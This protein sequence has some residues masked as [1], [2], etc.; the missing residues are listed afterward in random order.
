M[1]GSHA[2]KPRWGQPMTGI[3]A[4][5]VFTAIAWITWYIFGD[6]AKG[7][8]RLYEQPFTAFLATM[9]VVGVWQHIIFGDWPF[10]NLPP[11]QRGIAMTVTNL[12]LTWF[13]IYCLFEWMGVILPFWGTE[14]LLE[15][16]LKLIE[17][18]KLPVPAHGSELYEEIHHQAMDVKMASV[19]FWVVTGFVT[20]PFWAIMFQHWPFAGRLPQPYLGLAEWCVTTV[21]TMFVYGL[22]VVPHFGNVAVPGF[23][24]SAFT[25]DPAYASY[26]KAATELLGAAGYTGY[27]PIWYA[28]LAPIG[29][30]N[31]L[32]IFGLYEWIVIVLFL[33][34]NTWLGWPWNYV[35]TQPLRGIVGSVGMVLLAYV[36]TKISLALIAMQWGPIPWDTALDAATA[37]EL[38]VRG[39]WGFRYYHAASIAAA[40]I[41][42]FLMWHHFFDDIPNQPGMWNAG[43]WIRF[44]GVFALAGVWM[45]LWYKICWPA[46]GIWPGLSTAGPTLW[47]MHELV[48]HGEPLNTAFQVMNKPPIWIFWWIIPLLFNEW[49]MHKWPFYVEEHE[50]AAAHH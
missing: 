45:W 47:Q 22:L 32:Y 38:G 44:F 23:L 31:Y 14:Q 43:W 40:T 49:F 30:K 42:P 35:K 15:Q 7:I 26:T 33:A 39:T 1:A 9:I 2:I 24:K 27:P 48:G 4:F 5:V 36:F 37:K 18:A 20:Y 19:T 17:L 34:A 46:F 25:L 13:I 50:H 10:Q 16:K 29:A 6:P 41:M 3:I 28:G 12:V 8:F 21:I 11:L